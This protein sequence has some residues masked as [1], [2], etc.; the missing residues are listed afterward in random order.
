LRGKVDPS[1]IDGGVLFQTREEARAEAQRQYAEVE[2]RYHD[3]QGNALPGWLAMPEGT[4]LIER[5]WVQV[6]TENF[7]EKYFGH[8]E[9]SL[10]KNEINKKSRIKVKSPNADTQK[11]LEAYYKEPDGWRQFIIQWARKLVPE[12]LKAPDGKPVSFT[13]NSVRNIISHGKG[14]LKILTMGD[15]PAMLKNDVLYHTEASTDKDGKVQRYYNYAYPI[16][17]EK[18]NWI[19]S[20]T[21]KEDANGNRVYDDEFVEEIK[22]GGL[23]NG[24]VPSTR[25][26]LTRPS[27]L[28]ILQK[29]LSVNPDSVSIPSRR[30]WNTAPQREA[31]P[32]ARRAGRRPGQAGLVRGPLAGLQGLLRELETQSPIKISNHDI[33]KMTNVG[34]S[35]KEYLKI[36]ANLPDIIEKSVY[37]TTKDK[38]FAKSHYP[39]YAY[40]VTGATIGQH[41][42]TIRSVLGYSNG[43]WTTHF[44]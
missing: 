21:V 23:P 32:P 25:G 3:A 40:T 17:F 27:I 20:I 26:K 35:N 24:T 15:L 43:V 44:I 5:Q 9:G 41:E 30:W 22:Q 31:Q 6:H 33:D 34:M 12:V 39:K 18:K 36:L 42:V 10:L 13:N 4:N 11:I 29:I 19:V 7:K 1:R 37:I 2:A 28:T 16:E 14:P 8:L 38:E